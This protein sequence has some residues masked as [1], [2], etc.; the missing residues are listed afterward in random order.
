MILNAAPDLFNAPR[1][2]VSLVPSQTELLYYLGLQES[3]IAI[4][5]F[6]VHP[7]DWQRTKTIIG[8]TK[9]IRLDKIKALNPDLIIANKEENIKEEIDT[10]ANDFRVWLTDVNNLNSALQMIIDIGQLTHSSTKATDLV[11]TIQQKFNHLIKNDK[12]INTA[13]LIW[14]N[15]YMTIGGDT[16]IHDMLCQCGLQNIFDGEKRY[17][18]ITIDQLNEHHCVLLLLSSEPYPFKKQ[19]IEALQSQLPDTRI[20][21]VDGEMFSWYGS[22]LLY[23][24]EYFKELIETIH[25]A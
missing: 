9:N 18:I 2:I 17:P 25:S 10:L 1:R 13:Y 8:G 4:T 7:E 3:T 24:T 5:R 12:K 20:L 19:H 15:P 14:Q 22:R 6:C 21:L 11:S 16:F 23:A